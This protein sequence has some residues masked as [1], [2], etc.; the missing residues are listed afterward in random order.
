MTMRVAGSVSD[1]IKPIIQRKI[2]DKTVEYKTEGRSM[3][4]RKLKM[5]CNGF[6]RANSIN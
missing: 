4:R 5:C 6:T 2:S 3:V 1:N